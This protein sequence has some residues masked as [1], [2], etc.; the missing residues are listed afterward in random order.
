MSDIVR[1]LENAEKVFHRVYQLAIS[2]GGIYVLDVALSREIGALARVLQAVST[3]NG[4]VPLLVHAYTNPGEV[5]GRALLIY[6]ANKGRLGDIVNAAK[7]AGAI[8]MSANYIRAEKL[9]S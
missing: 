9:S 4:E 1:S 8:I 2:M 3:A 5:T 6:P 7:N